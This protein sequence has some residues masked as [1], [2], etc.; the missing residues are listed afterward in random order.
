MEENIM[1]KPFLLK[2]SVLNGDGIYH[3]ENYYFDTQEEMV[4][5][6]KSHLGSD[7]RLEAAFKMEKL[8]SDIFV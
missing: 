7:F 2:C 1:W 6:A 8:N 5:F 4:E 3:N